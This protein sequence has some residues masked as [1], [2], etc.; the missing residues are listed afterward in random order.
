MSGRKPSPI[1]L[2]ASW[3]ALYERRHD[4]EVMPVRISRGRP[5]YWP[6]SAS[7]PYVPE[8]APTREEFHLP[9]AEFDPAYLARLDSIGIDRIRERLDAIGSGRPLALCC[10]ERLP[11]DCHRGLFAEWWLEQTGVEIPELSSRLEP[12]PAQLTMFDMG[13]AR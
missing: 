11:R 4:L 9:D 1:L 12:E 7:F 8:L 5:R 13:G 3:R 2:T 10:Y 6:Q